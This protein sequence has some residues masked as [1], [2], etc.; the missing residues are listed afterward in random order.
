MIIA[1]IT[2][3]AIIITG[4]R[5]VT[6]LCVSP[7]RR[8]R[9]RALRTRGINRVVF[10]DAKGTAAPVVAAADPAGRGAKETAIASS[11]PGPQPAL[12]RPPAAADTTVAQLEEIGRQ[13]ANIGAQ[14]Q[15]GTAA[16]LPWTPAFEAPASAA[17]APAPSVPPPIPSGHE[18]DAQRLTQQA[19]ANVQ[20]LVSSLR[21]ICLGP[22]C[23]PR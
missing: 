10:F 19:A 5:I 2:L 22:S 11:Q 16:Q 12:P 20:A 17:A 4:S 3:P 7:R 13:V 14:R 23:N 21:A 6:G 8:A 18:A 9:D 1:T 15:A